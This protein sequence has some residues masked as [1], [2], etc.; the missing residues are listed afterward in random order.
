MADPWRIVV[1]QTGHRDGWPIV[2][3]LRIDGKLPRDLFTTQS[4]QE[5]MEWAAR[6]MSTR[7]FSYTKEE[8]TLNRIC[9]VP[10]LNLT[11]Q[12]GG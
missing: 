3:E 6:F 10:V 11:S 12:Q 8:L 7:G 9:F 2:I 4:Q 1:D 5:A